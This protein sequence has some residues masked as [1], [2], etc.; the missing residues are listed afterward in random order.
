MLEFK[1]PGESAQNLIKD[2]SEASFIAEV[3]EASAKT[4]VIVDFWAPWCGPCKSLGPI[5]EAEVKAAAGKV[6]LAK[7]NVDEAQGIAAQLG[8]QSIPTVYAFFNQQA[9]DVFAGALQPAQVKEF[10]QKIARLAGADQT[11]E[12][13]AMAEEMLGQGDVVNAVQA[14]ASILS[15]QP[16][17]PK[18]YS[19]MIRGYLQLGELEKAEGL[20]NSAP[21]E[22]RE[23]S[24]MAPVKAQIELSKEVSS[25]GPVAELRELAEKSP[26]SRQAKFDLAM[27]LHAAGEI[28]EAIE[29]LL[30]LFRLDREWEEGLAK[31]QLFKI[32][33][34]LGPKD[35][36][37]LAGRRKL[38][39]IIFS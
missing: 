22:V 4:P 11:E 18:A 31:T 2:V 33:D 32:F 24:E 17:N 25:M 19:G 39:S 13:L 6:V 5:L 20:L 16:A 34:A 12:V 9:V 38:S 28:D 30:S 10:V 21:E 29:E 14:F 3:I 23:A 8:I 36:R 35:E 37:A 7:V 26:D 1:S 15:Q 27:G